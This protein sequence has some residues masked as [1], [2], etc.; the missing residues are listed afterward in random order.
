[1]ESILLQVALSADKYMWWQLKET[2][3]TEDQIPSVPVQENPLIFLSQ[4]HFSIQWFY[5]GDDKMWYFFF[6][7]E[8]RPI[9]LNV[10]LSELNCFVLLDNRNGYGPRSG[11][12]DFIDFDLLQTYSLLFLISANIRNHF[13]A[14][15]SIYFISML[16]H[17]N[18]V[19][20]V[21]ERY[22]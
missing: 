13:Q 15:F 12:I 4:L 22:M 9:S 8:K 7:H 21:P 5:S 2:Q 14:L 17:L 11:G 18:W 16:F 3:S 20:S 19:C 1:M 10:S 6:H